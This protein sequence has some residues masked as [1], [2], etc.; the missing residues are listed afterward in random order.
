M[1]IKTNIIGNEVTILIDGLP[2][3]RYKQSDF[4]GFQSWIDTEIEFKPWYKI[5]IYRYKTEPILLVYKDRKIW[6]SIL[7]LLNEI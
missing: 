2:H 7:K 5:E 3:L 6:E 1:E 4:S